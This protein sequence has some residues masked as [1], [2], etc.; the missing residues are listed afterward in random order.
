LPQFL[1]LNLLEVLISQNTLL[2]DFIAFFQ[3]RD[4]ID[5]AGY[6]LLTINK[7]TVRVINH[8]E[9]TYHFL[10]QHVRTNVPEEIHQR[11]RGCS[12]R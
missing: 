5:V 8:C 2:G 4:T 9:P 12:H 6:L 10:G 7:L 1:K 3:E 11:L